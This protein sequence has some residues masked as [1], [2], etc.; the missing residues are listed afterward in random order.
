LFSCSYCMHLLRWCCV[1]RL[2]SPS[3]IHHRI[4][5][6][7][8]LDFFFD[9]RSPS[10]LISDA[11]MSIMSYNGSAMVAM[12]GKNCV[13]IASDMRFGVQQQTLADNFPKVYRIH[14][15]LFLGL[16]GLI[17]DMQTVSQKLEY[18]HKLYA[19]REER[20][21]KPQTFAA[22]VKN[23]LYERRFG[24]YFI[25]PIIAG[26]YDSDTEKNVPY[27][28]ATDLLGAGVDTT[29]FVVGGTAS[30]ELY[31]V[32]EA[33]YKP[34]ME[35]EDLFETISQALLAGVD[36]D[37]LSGWGAIVHIITPDGVI[38]RQLKSRKD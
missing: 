20:V 4:E 22:M 15:K 1:V 28:T 9:F 6:N 14:D 35:P 31:G 25:E 12:T 3:S 27:I 29:D 30:E 26:L 8:L 34:N 17:T 23:M 16:T 33:M 2:I 11:T 10:Q 13:A 24:P 36:R 5:S 32:C 21:M 19:L 18:R 7:L 37:C 38:E